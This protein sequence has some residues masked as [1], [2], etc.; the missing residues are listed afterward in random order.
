M[1]SLLEKIVGLQPGDTAT[2]VVPHF[3]WTGD[4]LRV[5]TK[6]TVTAVGFLNIDG[7]ILGN[8]VV[9]GD[10]TTEVLFLANTIKKTIDP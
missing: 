6:V 1:S 5:G 3:I 4:Y 7:L 10:C 9:R 2:V 8:V